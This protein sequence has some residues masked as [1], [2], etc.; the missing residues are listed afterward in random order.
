MSVNCVS[1]ISSTNK[2]AFGV[3][4][5]KKPEYTKSSV[6]LGLGLL[7]PTVGLA[8]YDVVKQKGFKNFIQAFKTAP[9]T[10]KMLNIKLNIITSVIG[11]VAG[12]IV[13]S[14]INASREQ[15]AREASNNI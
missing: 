13:D 4:N 11:V 3:N 1:G 12:L 6:G 14:V 2:M 8:G 5:D 7:I 15:K 9:N 10:L